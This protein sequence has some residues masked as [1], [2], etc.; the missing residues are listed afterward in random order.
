MMYTHSRLYSMTT[1]MPPKEGG[2]LLDPR[3]I[4]TPGMNPAGLG[5]TA[6]TRDIGQETSK[7]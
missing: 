7:I 1:V 2:P 5:D 6:A 3:E 4:Q